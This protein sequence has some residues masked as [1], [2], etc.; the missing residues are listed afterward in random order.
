MALNKA[1]SVTFSWGFTPN[2]I[3]ASL[4]LLLLALLGIFAGELVSPYFQHW[5]EVLFISLYG[6]FY[7]AIKKKKFWIKNKK[8]GNVGDYMIKY[9]DKRE[10]K[11]KKYL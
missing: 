7:F 1:K 2:P 8:N 9:F 3:G 6:W 5:K 11:S 10:A 4:V